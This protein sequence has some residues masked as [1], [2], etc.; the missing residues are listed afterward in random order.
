MARIQ[1]KPGVEAVGSIDWDRRLFDE[2]IPLPDGTSYNAYLVSGSEKVALLDTVDPAKQHELLAQL[3]GVGQ[4][5]YIIAHHAEQDHSGAIPAVLARYPQA[6]VLA[7]PKGVQ[8]LQD[9]LALPPEVCQPMADGA[10]LALGGR[11]LRFLHLPWVHWPET[12]VTFLEEDRILFSCDLFGSHLASSDLF[13]RD[14]AHVLGAAR[15][16]FAQIMMPYATLIRKHLDKLAPL[17]SALIAPSHGPLYGRP[18]LIL[19][20]YRHWTSGAVA[21]KVLIPF[22]SMHGSTALL[23]ER[24]T[25]GL[26]ACGVE[27][28]PFDLTNFKLDQYAA[29]LVDA[30]TVVFAAPAAMGGTHPLAAFAAMLAD[31]FRP[32]LKFAG[33]VGSYGWSRGQIGKT[34]EMLP[35]LKPEILEP[36]LCAGRPRAADLEAVD[37]LA[38]LIA[39]KHAACSIA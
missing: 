9:H 6:K 21:N 37:R 1:I 16:Y 5:D 12:M 20:A 27:V 23:V 11:T 24:L 15:L 22:V 3:E 32:P 19:D 10:A 35:H 18:A 28:Q 2:L 38:A 26:M 31:A 25:A 29:Q 33:Y 30:A 39:A 8:F 34:A 4:L 36:V 13:V 17:D 14:E 7:S